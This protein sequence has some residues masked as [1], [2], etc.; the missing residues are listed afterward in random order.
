MIKASQICAYNDVI[1]DLLTVFCHK[2]GMLKDFFN[3]PANPW[4]DKNEPSFLS[5][6]NALAILTFASAV[7]GSVYAVV[8][9]ED[10][11]RTYFVPKATYS[12]VEMQEVGAVSLPEALVLRMLG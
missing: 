8:K 4:H 7:V 3:R 2:F 6:G 1:I 11:I 9:Y 10:D 12:K 5:V